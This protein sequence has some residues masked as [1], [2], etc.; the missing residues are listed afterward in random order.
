MSSIIRFD[1]FALPLTHHTFNKST[2]AT[3][4][5]LTVVTLMS[6]SITFFVLVE[7]PLERC[8]IAKSVIPSFR[9]DAAER[10]L[11]L[12]DNSTAFLV[13][14]ICISAGARP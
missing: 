6:R 11:A 10:Y 2:R 3:V 12:D 5:T 13:G 14:S 4:L 7:N 8:A 1:R 9:R